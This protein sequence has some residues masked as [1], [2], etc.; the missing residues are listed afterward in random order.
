MVLA[1][2]FWSLYDLGAP[3]EFWFGHVRSSDLMLLG[4]EGYYDFGMDVMVTVCSWN[5]NVMMVWASM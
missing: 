1:R 3:K 4:H 5:T 2:M